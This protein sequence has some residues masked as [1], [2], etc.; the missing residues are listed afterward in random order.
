METFMG[1]RPQ[2]R[3]FFP[4]YTLVGVILLL[5]LMTRTALLMRPDSLVP[6]TAVNLLEVFG[7]G[8]FFDSVAACYFCLPL[9]LY[10]ALLPNALARWRPLRWLF[11]LLFLVTIYLLWVLAVAEWVFWDEFGVRFNF[12]AVDYLIY[13]HEV[14]GNVWESYP[15]GKVLLLLGV[16]ALLMWLPL[17][18][19]I[20]RALEYPSGW[21]ARLTGLLPWLAAPAL[22]LVF[23]SSDMKRVSP[24][25]TVDELAGNG[26]YEFFAANRNNELNFESFYATSPQEQAMKT[27]HRLLS[28]NGERSLNDQPN[29][30]ERAIANSGPEKRYNIVLI[31]I[32]SMGS[33]FLG[34]FGN[35]QAIT[36]NLDA[37]ASQSLFFANL[38]STGNRTVRGMEALALAIPPTPGQSIVKR[39]NNE[40]LFSLGSVL[41]N[42]GYDTQFLYGGYGY[43]D[44]MSYFFSHNNYRVIDRHALA[45]E[46][47]HYEN[48]W[49]VADEDLFTL[50]LLEMDR[51]YSEHG[52][53]KPF[54]TH[55]MTTSNHRPY[56]Y[57]A[58][59]IDIPS[60]SGREGAVKYTDYAVGDFLR[61]A[62]AKAWFADTIFVITADHGASA[63]GTTIP[64]EKYRIP[65]FIYSPAHIEPKRIERLMS[66]ID[67][68]PTLLG[69]LNMSYVSKFYGYDILKLPV[70][71]DR[72]FVS[73]Y[74]V[75]G[76]MKAGRMVTL[77][78]QRKVNITALPADVPGA[79]ATS[80]ISDA[81]LRDEAI[82]LYQS[83]SYA[84]KHGL[85]GYEKPG[86]PIAVR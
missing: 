28:P 37:L 61:R 18:K 15:V 39:P 73:N 46:D 32:E 74:Q 59:R 82:S 24:I 36:P 69:L 54:F 51:T 75:L 81:E 85:Y 25:G 80:P 60:G 9:A 42:K 17:I 6:L 47:I 40:D 45:R 30:S 4:L 68:P 50:A 77:Q 53:K 71:F 29:S 3:R 44:N 26:S 33:E 72:A 22:A 86:D 66:Q 52:G 19:S 10:L 21:V 67:I 49:G 14:L 64:L 55:I 5:S 79:T 63:R 16:V 31:S 48:I 78:P 70:G 84:F 41:R 65:L 83:A 57:P 2:Y 62:R 1:L 76:Y 38:F 58:N 43:F 13:T 27:M 11:L 23:V 56:T 8:L 12:I 34:S 35:R 20:Y 7:I